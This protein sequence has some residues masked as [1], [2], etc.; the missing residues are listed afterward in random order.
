MKIKLSPVRSDSQPLVASVAGDVI[1]VNDTE[2]DLSPLAIGEELPA[3]EPFTGSIVRDDHGVIHLTLMLPHGVN[4]PH[5]TRFP[6]A[7]SEPM[8]I[9]DGE[10]PVP[11]YDEYYA[12]VMPEVGDA[13]LAQ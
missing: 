7:F 4:A 13:G 10:I 5:E 1:T 2:Y 3:P 6:A 12:K 8:D 11:P 9:A